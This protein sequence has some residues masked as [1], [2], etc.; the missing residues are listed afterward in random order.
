MSCCE[1]RDDF[2]GGECCFDECRRE[3]ACEGIKEVKR[4]AK[5]IREGLKNIEEARAAV[6]HAT[7]EVENALKMLKI[8]SKE[9]E[10]AECADRE[11]LDEIYVGICKIEKGISPC[12]GCH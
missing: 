5:E 3:N 2:C 9:L 11:G 1:E 7:R 8:A 12:C 10:K 6:A 4:G